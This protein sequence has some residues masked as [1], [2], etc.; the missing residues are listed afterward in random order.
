[1]LTIPLCVPA[2]C[3]ASIH[4]FFFLQAS[5]LHN[6]HTVTLL[7]Q[8]CP[9]FNQKALNPLNP[10]S[11]TLLCLMPDDFTHQLS[12]SWGCHTVG[13]NGFISSSK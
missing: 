13:V 10:G 1:M 3:P 7:L 9:E 4:S 6:K 12:V 11:E 5:K 8:K 2:L